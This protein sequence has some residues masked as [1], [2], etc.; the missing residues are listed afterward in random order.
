MANWAQTHID[1]RLSVCLTVY[2]FRLK[3][4]ARTRRT[5]ADSSDSDPETTP[6]CTKDEIE[7]VNQA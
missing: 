4:N 7:K 2:S 6:L 3:S 5:R 1:A